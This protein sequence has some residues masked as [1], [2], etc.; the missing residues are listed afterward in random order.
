M[1]KIY[2]NTKQLRSCLMDQTEQIRQCAALEDHLRRAQ[3]FALPEDMYRIRKFRELAE[4]VEH[5]LRAARDAL[6]ETCDSAE[7]LSG[8]FQEM[9]GDVRHALKK[10]QW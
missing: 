4:N 10:T 1:D 3:S 2:I 9:M 5:Y 7:R 6:E 8:E